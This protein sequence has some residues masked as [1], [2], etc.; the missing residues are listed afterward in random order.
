MLRYAEVSQRQPFV[1]SSFTLDEEDG[2][3]TLEHR[4]ALNRVLPRWRAPLA[5]IAGEEYAK[6]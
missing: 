2:G 3:C 1:L 5:A 4:V 6:D